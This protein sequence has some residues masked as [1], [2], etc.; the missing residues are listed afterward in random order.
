[1]EKTLSA[2]CELLEGELIGDGYIRIH[3]VNSCAMAQDG[4]LTY[5]ESSKLLEQALESRAAGIIVPQDVKDLKGRSGIR[6]RNPHLAFAL[7]LELFH[8]QTAFDPGIHDTVVLGKNVQLGEGVGVKAHAVIGDDVIIGKGTLIGSGVSIGNEVSIGSNCVLDSN[9]VIYRQCQLGDR[10]QIHAGTVVGG[11]G[12]GYTL[13][14]D[15]YVKVPQVGNVIIEDDVELGCNVCVDRATVGSTIIRKGTKIDNLVQ[16]AHNNRI[17]KHVL[18]SGHVGL[19][20]SVTVGDYTILGG[21]VGV[22]DHVRIGEHVK[23]GGASVITKNVPDG[24]TVWGYPARPLRV[25]KQQLAALARLPEWL[26]EK[27]R[28]EK[29]SR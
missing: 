24:E 3:G 28:R 23:A 8:P 9:V 5:A 18:L 2:L 7:L 14:Q 10:V 19:A 27:A 4:E 12:F 29:Q 22:V 6:V 21:K 25:M 13:N 16:I 26:K 20:G 1:M 15:A 11:D 17:G